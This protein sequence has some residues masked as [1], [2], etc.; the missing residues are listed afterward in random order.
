[1]Q[2]R[3]DSSGDR[4]AIRVAE[5]DKERRFQVATG[6]LQAPCDFRR[7]DISGY[8]DDEQLAEAGVE[9]QLGRHP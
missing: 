1:M 4:A 3:L 6:V 9:D 8:A 5:D 7:H 2:S